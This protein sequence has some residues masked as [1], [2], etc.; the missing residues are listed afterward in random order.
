MLV[1]GGVIKAPSINAKYL[2]PG[3][4]GDPF[5]MVSLRDPF[6]G[7]KGDLLWTIWGSKGHCFELP[8]LWLRFESPS[9]YI[10]LLCSMQ[11]V[12]IQ[13]KLYHK[14]FGGE[15]PGLFCTVHFLG[16]RDFI[17]KK[18]QEGL[19]DTL[20]ARPSSPSQAGVSDL[21]QVRKEVVPSCCWNLQLICMCIIYI[22]IHI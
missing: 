22:Y 12:Y 16:A 19:A 17:P 15:S 6:N 20:F 14:V 13:I 2:H 21:G 3:N 7:C 4:A 1:F 11:N 5:G 9:I 8:E 18:P 10:Y